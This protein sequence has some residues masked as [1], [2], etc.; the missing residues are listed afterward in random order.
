[1]GPRLTKG[2]QAQPDPH[3]RQL[4][5][6]LQE[7]ESVIIANTNKNLGPVGI[8]VEHYIKLGLDHLLDPSTYELLTESQADQVIAIL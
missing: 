6:S 4:L 8:D 2:R 7:N 1:M 3:Q 5:A